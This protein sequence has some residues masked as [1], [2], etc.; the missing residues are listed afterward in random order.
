MFT[1]II[2]RLLDMIAKG[3]DSLR[4][5]S[6]GAAIASYTLFMAYKVRHSKGAGGHAPHA[7]PT[8]LPSRPGWRLLT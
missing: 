8:T 1:L 5:T 3:L 7:A 6:T 4:Q 2:Q